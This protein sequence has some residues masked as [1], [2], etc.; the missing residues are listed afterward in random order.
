MN[1]TPARNLFVFWYQDDWGL[2][3]RR[4][5]ALTRAFAR[6]ETRLVVHV[7]PAVDLL[8]VL[9]RINRVRREKDAGMR[10][11]YASQARRCLSPAPRAVDDKL[12]VYT[13]LVPFP[14]LNLPGFGLL[15]TVNRWSLTW[16]L[17]RLAAWAGGSG[18]DGNGLLLLYP[19]QHYTDVILKVFG[20]RG[21]RT[22][23]DLVDDKLA[24]SRTRGVPE[25]V[26]AR[27]QKNYDV[28]MRAAK[29]AFCV[30]DDMARA[31]SDRYGRP[32]EHIPN[33]VPSRPEGEVPLPRPGEMAE[34]GARYVVYVG[35]INFTLDE[36]IAEAALE[37][38][39][40]VRFVFVGPVQPEV[41]DTWERLR[42]QYPNLTLTGPRV[43]A[44]AR[45]YVG[46][47]D[48]LVMFKK[49]KVV[50]G[51]DSMKVYEYLATGKPAVVTPV[52][53]ADRFADLLYVAEEAKPFCDRLAE[54]L[55]ENAPAVQEKR[56]AAVAEQ[57]W[58]HRAR[59]M[60]RRMTETEEKA[61]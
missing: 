45:A 35:N 40:D 16:Q 42:R 1:R 43:A 28:A 15:E 61:G 20:R 31:F 44:E 26:L 34:E 21:Y 49:P 12:Y 38:F 60:W 11:A 57:T 17:R 39:P 36:Q 6:M 29:V 24:R 47:A 10:M 52:P 32:V 25:T 3:S 19:P 9:R 23:V 4:N 33:G 58:E 37:R 22:C 8:G 27:V 53:P 7:E 55:E 54:A 46:A 5:E 30:A 41:G 13:P 59:R 18:V 2:Y 48:V 14:T 50:K 51:G 56:R